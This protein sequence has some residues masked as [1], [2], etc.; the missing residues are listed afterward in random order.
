MSEKYIKDEQILKAFAQKIDNSLFEEL[1]NSFLEES[2]ILYKD[3]GTFDI[4]TAL[5]SDYFQRSACGEFVEAEQ[6]LS[7]LCI[8]IEDEELRNVLIDEFE[9]D[10]D[11]IESEL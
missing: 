6:Y 9:L 10:R 2:V 7:E 1:T 11:Y 3:D 5:S 4:V 8:H